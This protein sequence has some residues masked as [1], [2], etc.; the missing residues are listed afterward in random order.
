MNNLKKLL[1]VFI[2]L[3]CLTYSSTFADDSDCGNFWI[4]QY[5][6][7]LS[8]VNDSWET[9]INRF[10]KFLTDEQQKAI[11]TKQDLN[12][13]I[14][15]LQKYCCENNL[16]WL[17]Q[18]SES[19]IKNKPFFNDNSLDSPYLFD[20]IFDVIMRRLNWLSWDYNI[21]NG[22][23]LDDKWAERRLKI[24]KY[25]TSSSW[26]TPQTITDVYSWFWR[27]SPP[28]LEYNIANKIDNVFSEKNNQDFLSYVSWLWWEESKSV[29]NAMKNYSWWTMYDRYINACALTEY[30]Y[31]LLNQNQWTD[32]PDKIRNIDKISKNSCSKI[33]KKQIQ[34]EADYVTLIEQRA[35]NKF[36]SNYIEWYISYMYERQEKLQDLIKNAKNRRLDVVR[37]V[38]SL[39]RQCIK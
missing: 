33:V 27:Q 22:M 19:C 21:Y 16:W 10:S 6:N 30:F 9:D 20:H 39:Q 26:T 23:T 2:F 36:Q 8:I 15:N 17:S 38:P 25:A 29:A 14:L 32:S 1:S 11:I 35:S 12:I 7:W 18:K 5:D 4:L 34:W 13:A 28:K 37:A 31:A 24:T 3:A